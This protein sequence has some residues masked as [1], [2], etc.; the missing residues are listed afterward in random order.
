MGFEHCCRGGFLTIER[1]SWLFMHQTGAS[2]LS[3]DPSVLE[4][5]LTLTVVTF[6]LCLMRCALLLRSSNLAS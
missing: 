5:V 3:T 2:Q 6:R 1:L 4:Q